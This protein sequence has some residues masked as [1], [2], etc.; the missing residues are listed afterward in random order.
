MI[1]II[2]VVTI[3]IIIIMFLW[4]VNFKLRAL[5]WSTSTAQFT[6]VDIYRP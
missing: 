2:V 3:T 4:Y 1:V 6:C 5:R